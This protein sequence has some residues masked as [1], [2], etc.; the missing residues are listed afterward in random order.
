MHLTSL[1]S[2]AGKVSSDRLQWSEDLTTSFQTAKDLL[3]SHKSITLPKPTDTIWIVTDGAVK[4]PGLGATMYITRDGQSPK[5]AGYFS[6]K[7]K[8]RQLSWIPCELEALAIAA[9]V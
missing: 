4:Y 8:Q 3:K 5:V 2:V 7:L 9:A 1:D 6:A